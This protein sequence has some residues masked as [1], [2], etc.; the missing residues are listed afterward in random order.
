MRFTAYLSL[1][2]ITL[3]LAAC[4]SQYSFPKDAVTGKDMD[5]DYRAIQYHLMR[6]PDYYFSMVIPNEWKILEASGSISPEGTAPLELAIFREQGP[7]MQNENGRVDAEIVVNVVN[8]SGSLVG[9]SDQTPTGWLKYRLN[10]SLGEY[11]VLSERTINSLF[12]P[13]ADMLVRSANGTNGYLISRFSALRSPKYDQMFVIT[14]S[15]PEDA[16]ERNADTFATAIITFKLDTLKPN[17][18]KAGTG[19][20]KAK[21]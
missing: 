7:W 10:Q 11:T 20:V 18:P 15:A 13:Q 4:G 1:S 12:G 19:A 5:E 14:A 3:T 9:L 2:L 21:E 16:Y 8:L 17:K 6:N